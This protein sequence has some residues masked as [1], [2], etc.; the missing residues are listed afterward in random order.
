[1]HAQALG[2]HA[3]ERVEQFGDR[4]PAA[5]RRTGLEEPKGIGAVI[6]AHAVARGQHELCSCATQLVLVGE[7][8]LANT[9]DGAF[10]LIII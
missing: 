6:D 9:T 1:M 8:R 3:I 2:M 10:H 7:G 5:P 4:T